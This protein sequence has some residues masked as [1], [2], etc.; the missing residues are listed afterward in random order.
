MSGYIKFV[1]ASYRRE[2]DAMRMQEY[3][4][5]SGFHVDLGTLQ[6]GASDTDSFVMAAELEGSLI[7]TMRG[8]LI[9][10]ASLLERKL[11]CEWNFPV[12]LD[13][14]V[15]LLSRAATLSTHRGSGLNLVLRYW[16]LRLAEHFAIPFVIGTFVAASPRENTLRAMGYE[17]F[18]NKEGWQQ[19]SYRSLRKVFVVS[20]DM[21]KNGAGALRFC[22]ERMGDGIRDFQFESE[23]PKLKVVRGL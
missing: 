8:E 23:F 3:G 11:E 15:L 18:E 5:A 4:K 14:P 13:F 16:F 10:D 9:I 7:A 21:Q 19:S 22:Q 12:E 20:L 2:I 17:F 1:D 6:W